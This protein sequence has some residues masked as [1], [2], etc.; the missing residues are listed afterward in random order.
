MI[1]S[2]SASARTDRNP[3]TWLKAAVIS[4]M[5]Q[6]VIFCKR[7]LYVRLI[8]PRRAFLSI[9]KAGPVQCPAVLQ[10]TLMATTHIEESGVSHEAG[11]QLQFHLSK[12]PS[13]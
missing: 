2:L 8:P 5:P 12:L 10:V 3:Q 7:R 9:N 4:L 11:L 6:S 1:K 13:C